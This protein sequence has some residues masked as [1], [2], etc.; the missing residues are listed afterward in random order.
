MPARDCSEGRLGMGGVWALL[1]LQ[2]S[3]VSITGSA[4]SICTATSVKQGRASNRRVLKGVPRFAEF[5]ARLDGQL[6]YKT[7]IAK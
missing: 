1:K 7:L 4:P 6:T 5:L 3:T 2:I